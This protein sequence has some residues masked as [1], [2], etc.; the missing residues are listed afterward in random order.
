MKLKTHKA[1]SKRFR[2][3]KTGKIEKRT[4]GQNHFNSRESGKVGRN[5][6]SD[7]IVSRTLKDVM[8]VALPN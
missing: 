7:V 4:S 1:T 5:K 3:T 2:I 8:K 6:K